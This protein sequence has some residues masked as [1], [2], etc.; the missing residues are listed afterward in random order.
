MHGGLKKREILH[1]HGKWVKATTHTTAVLLWLS[2]NDHGPA[3]AKNQVLPML[4]EAKEESS[5]CLV[6]RNERGRE[7]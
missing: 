4:R 6:V 3:K 1:R 7:P 5:L 2:G